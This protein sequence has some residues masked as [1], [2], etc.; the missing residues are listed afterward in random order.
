MYR[1]TGFS[2]G[3][4][5]TGEPFV[6]TQHFDICVSKEHFVNHDYDARMS[7]NTEEDDDC[8]HTIVIYNR[9]GP[10]TYQC[11]RVPGNGTMQLGTN[12][13]NDICVSGE[14]TLSRY[15]M[16]LILRPDGSFTV[17]AAG[18]ETGSNSIFLPITCTRIAGGADFSTTNRIKYIESGFPIPQVGDTLDLAKCM[19]SIVTVK[20]A[21]YCADDTLYQQEFSVG[22]SAMFTCGNFML[23][24][25]RQ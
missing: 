24:V 23:L 20:G 11:S 4:R 3:T 1:L 22:E 21:L 16:R 9:S 17:K 5:P 18:Y 14:P 2:A 10:K 7:S 15:A 19:C 25:R 12:Q 13:K 6:K 8:T